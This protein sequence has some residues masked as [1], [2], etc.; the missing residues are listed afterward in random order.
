MQ[1]RGRE[2]K[3]GSLGGRSTCSFAAPLA[4]QWFGVGRT[5]RLKEVHSESSR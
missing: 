3:E 4:A 1:G 2:S 5:V